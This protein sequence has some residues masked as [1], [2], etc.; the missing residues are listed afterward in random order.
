MPPQAQDG[1]NC[2]AL[3]LPRLLLRLLGQ[4][5]SIK[6]LPTLTFPPLRALFPL[7]GAQKRHE[8]PF[9]AEIS[10]GAPHNDGENLENLQFSNAF[11][12][13]ILVYES[14]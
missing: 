2:T 9:L 1:H 7:E 5:F 11:S 6:N 13:K 8:E 3:P 14:A 4:G 12:N 10:A